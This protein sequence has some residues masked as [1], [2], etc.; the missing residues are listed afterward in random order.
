MART[1]SK[2]TSP[3]V[4][5]DA[6]AEVT[7]EPVQVISRAAAI[8]VAKGSGMVCLRLPHE[9]QAGRRTQKVREVTA[10]F[11]AVVALMDHLVCQGVERLVL[12]S[13]SGGFHRRR[14][15]L[16]GPQPVR[17]RQHPAPGGREAA[18]L[19]RPPCRV[20][21]RRHP[22]RRV[23]LRLADIDAAHP[24]PVQRLIGHLFHTSLHLPV[25]GPLA[26]C[27]QEAPPGEPG[28]SGKKLTRVLVAT[29]NG[30]LKDRFP[31]S[32]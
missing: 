10:T 27:C 8:D 17:Q 19:L 3:S 18:G 2:P 7:D 32:G 9:S 24:V 11:A 30:P 31:A 12:E 23:H 16:P 28:A 14:G 26:C 13:T 5:G 25:P 20:L 15:H 29:V 21:I 1:R 4:P 6:G 22:D